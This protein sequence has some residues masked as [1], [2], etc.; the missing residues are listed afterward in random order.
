M[1]L[2]EGAKDTNSAAAVA[3]SAI[4]LAQTKK[5]AMAGQIA[6]TSAMSTVTPVPA[7]PVLMTYLSSQQLI[8]NTSVGEYGQQT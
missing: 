2:L 3:Q 1:A 7:T 8:G 6:A 5:A 4:Q